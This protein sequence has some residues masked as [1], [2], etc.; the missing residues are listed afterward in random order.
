M[1]KTTTS[2]PQRWPALWLRLLLNFSLIRERPG[3]RLTIFPTAT[4]VFYPRIS[5]PEPAFTLVLDTIESG[6]LLLNSPPPGGATVLRATATILLGRP[7]VGAL[8]EGFALHM[9]ILKCG[10]TSRLFQRANSRY[11]P[12]VI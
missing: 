10:R 2:T 12:R 3:R 1:C 7:L 5:D 8:Q 6:A 11:G 4:V 9:W